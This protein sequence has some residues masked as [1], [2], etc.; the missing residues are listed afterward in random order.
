M[1]L[2]VTDRVVDA[3][4]FYIDFHCCRRERYVPQ[5]SCDLSVLE[6]IF[7]ISWSDVWPVFSAVGR[8]RRR[9]MVNSGTESGQLCHNSSHSGID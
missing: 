3:S 6:Q 7:S 4:C 5:W 2:I 9:E 1:L 8:L